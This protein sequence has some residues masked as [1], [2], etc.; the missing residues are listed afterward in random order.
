MSGRAAGAVFALALAGAMTLDALMPAEPVIPRASVV[1][2]SAGVL[3]C[4]FA[5]DGRGS[6]YLY[7]ANVGTAPST[8]RV[9]VIPT[10]GRVAVSSIRVGA[11]SVR[12][13]RLHGL[14]KEKASAVVEYAGGEIVASHALWFAGRSGAR[15]AGG[16]TCV[17]P[18]PAE[19][20]VT[21][22][23]TFRAETRLALVNPG[24]GDADVTVTLLADGHTI[25]PEGLSQ[26]VVPARAR[27]EFR[28]GDYAFDARNL[29]AIVRSS[30]GRVVAE[31][32]VTSAAG[33]ELIGALVPAANAAAMAARSGAGSSFSLTA[34][35]EDDA[36]IDARLVTVDRQG[37]APGIPPALAPG[38]TRRVA[39]PGATKD[40]P[41]AYVSRVTVGSPLVAG[42]SWS[43]ARS[44]SRD[45]AA[46][47]GVPFA[48]RW[49]GVIGMTQPRSS[50]RALIL[51][52]GEDPATVRVEVLTSTGA[53]GERTLTIP[54]GR[55]ATVNV[56][57]GGN[58]FGVE[59]RSDTPVAIVLEGSATSPQG[60]I[61]GLGLPAMPLYP[62][63][64]VAVIRDPRVGVPAPRAPL[65]AEL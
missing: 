54:P 18:V 4:P 35:G 65:H 16:G 41:A 14:V 36:G 8:A 34:T 63:S 7:L 37:K 40:G 51:N 45:A 48:R 9:T 30:A 22:A 50:A 59:A 5:Y 19:S 1:S 25:A 56:G 55:I 38:R 32:L 64:P 13:V 12:S 46:V 61:F 2:S 44:A 58:V 6:A 53:R 17:R 23:R 29:T 10:R 57:T 20:V 3:A 33:V 24:N 52:P 31:A 15:G 21:H 28:L 42:A 47:E 43:V 60:Q 62:A 26:R 49:A 11:R 39:I 27:R